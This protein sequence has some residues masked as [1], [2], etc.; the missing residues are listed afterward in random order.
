MPFVA[1]HRGGNWQVSG[2][3]QSAVTIAPQSL[4]PF[5]PEQSVLSCGVPADLASGVEAIEHLLGSSIEEGKSTIVIEDIVND[6]CF[7]ESPFV[8]EKGIHFCAGEPLLDS[9]EQLVG[10]VLVLDTRPRRMSEHEKESLHTAAAATL[11]AL[12]L[13]AVAP[14]VG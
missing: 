6:H 3:R 10:T 2:D 11:E 8:H 13:R 12:E 7:A 1:S 9:N 4:T 14:P 5:D